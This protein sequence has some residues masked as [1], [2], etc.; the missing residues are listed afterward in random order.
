MPGQFPPFWSLLLPAPTATLIQNSLDARASDTPARQRALWLAA[1]GFALDPNA[2]TAAPDAAWAD[3]A[4]RADDRLCA[5]APDR[6]HWPVPTA[7]PDQAA[8][9]AHQA[10]QTLERALRYG[11]D[12]K[13]ATALRMRLTQAAQGIP[14]ARQQLRAA[15]ADNLAR[16]RLLALLH[17]ADWTMLA[18]ALGLDDRSKRMV[19]HF[20]KSLQKMAASPSSSARG[21]ANARHD[22][23]GLA[24]LEKLSASGPAGGTT[25]AEGMKIAVFRRMALHLSAQTGMPRSAAMLAF[26]PEFDSPKDRVLIKAQITVWQQVKARTTA[27]PTGSSGLDT[28]RTT[29]SSPPNGQPAQEKGAATAPAGGRASASPPSALPPSA[30]SIAGQFAPPLPLCCRSAGK[31]GPFP[32]ACGGGCAA[33][34]VSGKVF[35]GPEHHHARRLCLA[36]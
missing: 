36:L 32:C 8:P 7:V 12:G 35:R 2:A 23:L 3:I 24:L 11:I 22:A 28:A 27:M 1:L 13:A 21:S 26:H 19:A 14:A 5:D 18:Q 17:P 31:S 34:A 20:P 29:D 6:P 16:K 15:L 4:R 10:A 30:L 9:A 25:E 33:V